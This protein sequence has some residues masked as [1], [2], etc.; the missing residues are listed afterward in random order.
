[1]LQRSPL[2]TLLS[3]QELIASASDCDVLLLLIAAI[4]DP[5]I[6]P[7]ISRFGQFYVGALPRGFCSDSD[8]AHQSN[9]IDRTIPERLESGLKRSL[10]SHSV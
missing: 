1:L 10:F 7:G 3:H 9:P 8:A 5:G 2:V 6:D 4:V